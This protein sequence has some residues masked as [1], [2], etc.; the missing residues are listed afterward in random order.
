MR[1]AVSDDA[2]TQCVH[3]DTD[4]RSID[5]VAI[6]TLVSYYHVVSPGAPHTNPQYSQPYTHGVPERCHSPLRSAG[7]DDEDMEEVGRTAPMETVRGRAPGLAV[8]C[9]LP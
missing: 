9:G 8:L 5:T 2:M 1:V 6:P 3:I 7:A 4:T